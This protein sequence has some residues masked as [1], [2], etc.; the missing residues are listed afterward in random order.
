MELPCL[1]LAWWVG[2]ARDT[3]SRLS[4]DSYC[5]SSQE[6]VYI[7][8]FGGRKKQE[9]GSALYAASFG[10]SISACSTPSCALYSRALGSP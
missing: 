10:S 8:S 7:L 3:V 5:T 9:G 6:C 1:F 2:D 4:R